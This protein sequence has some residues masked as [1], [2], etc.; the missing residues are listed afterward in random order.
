MLKYRIRTE[1]EMMA[2]HGHGWENISLYGGGRYVRYILGRHIEA[3]L[4]SI[5]DR[6]VVTANIRIKNDDPR[7]PI[8]YFVVTPADVITYD[9]RSR[10]RIKTEQEFLEE[11]GDNWRA[12][13]VFNSE[14]R[15]DY[16][17]G[18]EITVSLQHTNDDGDVTSRF[19]IYNRNTIAERVFWTIFPPMVRRIPAPSYEPRSEFYY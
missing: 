9:D 11:F 14:G 5:N 19:R 17:L 15:M 7:L 3:P 1:E 18:Q 8:G 13:V 16:L 12:E 2:E 6:G 4:E 10:Y